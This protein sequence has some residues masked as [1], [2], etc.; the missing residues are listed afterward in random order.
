[1]VKATLVGRIVA[2]RVDE[3]SRILIPAKAIEQ[4]GDHYTVEFAAGNTRVVK[5]DLVSVAPMWLSAQ[6]SLLRGM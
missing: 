5:A 4:T 1:M 2:V 6:W 3:K